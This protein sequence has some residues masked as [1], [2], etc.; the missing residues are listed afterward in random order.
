[1]AGTLSNIR[2]GLAQ[3]LALIPGLRVSEQLPE[4]INPPVAIITRASVNYQKAMV[5]GLTEWS[6]EIQL[7]AGRMAEQ[8]SQRQIDAWLSWDGEQSIRRA[9]EA[10]PTLGG[11]VETRVVTRA[12][13]LS[14]LQIGDA[15]YITVTVELTVWA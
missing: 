5:G 13:A 1:M 10:D 8:A 15:D 9:V 12:N 14:S 7:V 4:Q 6:M 2:Q 3:Q 11:N